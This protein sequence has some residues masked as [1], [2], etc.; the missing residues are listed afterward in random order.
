MNRW[1]F[2]IAGTALIGAA[3]LVCAQVASEDQKAQGQPGSD[4]M[5]AM[6]AKWAELNAL[7][8]EHKAFADMVGK[9]DTLT[10]MWMAPEM[11]PM[12]SLGGA[13]F[14]LMLGGRYVQQTYRCPSMGMPFEGVG[15]TGYDKFKKKY[16]SI[17]MDSMST[18]IG[19][20]EGTPDAS[21]RVFT[22][23]GT[24]D[25]PLTGERGMMTRTVIRE[26]DDDKVVM[27]MHEKRSASDER[28]VMEIEYT[29][30][31]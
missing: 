14:E 12:E 24:V 1:T 21:G 28:K 23:Y 30:K 2:L 25:D 10:R 22:Y 15:I 7:G 18:A 31:P 27:E 29:R 11:P 20:S 3:L 26:V 19:I 6:M 9:W 17:W 8:P 5:A 13:E 16:V 4:E